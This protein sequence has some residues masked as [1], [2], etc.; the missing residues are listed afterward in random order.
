M[1]VRSLILPLACLGCSTTPS[2]V[3]RVVETPD[4]H[5][6]SIRENPD[7]FVVAGHYSEWQFVRNSQSGFDGCKQIINS[8]AEKFATSKGKSVALPSWDEI[9]IIDHGRDIITAIMNVNCQYS[10]TFLEPQ[11]DLVS[12]LERLKTLL[13]SGSISQRE[14]DAA[15][16]KLLFE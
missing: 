3:G 1:R 6:Y 10:Y 5:E 13:E 15:K 12:D 8:A 7:G 14:Y 2:H 16:K 11:A 4:G 9:E